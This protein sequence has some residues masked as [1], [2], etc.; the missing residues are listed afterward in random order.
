MNKMKSVTSKGKADRSKK[1][2]RWN[3]LNEIQVKKLTKQERFQHFWDE[4]DA[5]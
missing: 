5:R 4:K 2:F 3:L 1:H